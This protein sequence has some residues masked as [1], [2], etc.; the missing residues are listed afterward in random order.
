MEDVFVYRLFLRPPV[1]WLES[2]EKLKLN[3]MKKCYYLCMLIMLQVLC[4]PNLHLSAQTVWN[5]TSDVSWYVAGNT[6][7]EIST[8]EQLAGLATIVNNNTYDF[9]GDTIYL[10]ADIWLNADGSTTNN[11]TPIGGA[12]DASGETSGTQRYFR[13]SFFGEGHT[14]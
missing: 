14:I 12:P 13:G 11:W 9:Y 10:R 6:S 4:F 1:E 2:V 5:G 3:N 8:P 7:F